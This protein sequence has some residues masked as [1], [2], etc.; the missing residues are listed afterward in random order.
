MVEILQLRENH[1]SKNSSRKK[2]Y[3]AC[4]YK[5]N[6]F[7][8][9]KTIFCFDTFIF[10]NV[11]TCQWQFPD[12]NWTCRRYSVLVWSINPVFPLLVLDCSHARRMHVYLVHISQ[13]PPP[14]PYPNLEWM[15]RSGKS[16]LGANE[17]RR[18]R[19]S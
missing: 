4:S 9:C 14:L 19:V 17:D 12:L 10:I 15:V 18:F 5:F 11:F 7:H 6:T 2:S 8:Q 3:L 1:Q 13:P 16:C